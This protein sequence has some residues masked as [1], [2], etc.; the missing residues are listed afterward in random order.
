MP[1]RSEIPALF[2]S[3][4]AKNNILTTTETL[5]P[6]ECDGYTA[7]KSL[8]LAVLLPETTQQVIDIIKICQRETIPIVTRGAGTGLS[9]G[10]HPIS[11]G[12]LLNLSKLNQIL[13]INHQLQYAHV[14]PGVRNLAISEAASEFGLYYA[15]DPSSQI[16]CTIGGNI[17]E[18]SGGVHCLK[19]GLTVHNLLEVT[20]VTIDGELITIGSECYENPGYDMLALLAGSEGMLAVMV[21]AKVKLLPKPLH[22]EVILAAF[23]CVEEAG[24]AVANIIASGVIPAGLEMMDNAVINATENFCH[25]GYPTDA[26][27]ILLCELDGYDDSLQWEI[28]Q[29]TQQCKQSNAVTVQKAQNASEQ[30]LFWKGRKSAFPAIGQLS[31]DYLC[32]DGTIPRKH[33]AHVLGEI[34]NYSKQIG[35]AVANVFHAGDGNLHPLIMYDANNPGELEKAEEIGGKILELCVSV[36]GTITGEH[37]VGIEKLNQMCVQFKREELN[38]F[39]RIK[40]AFDPTHLLNPGKVIPTLQR[41]AEFGAM[42]VHRG[43]MPFKDLPRF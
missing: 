20:F 5:R 27:A 6:Y 22:K 35:L 13:E 2:S 25:A 36:G 31:P 30:E 37:G 9:G 3:C 28:E 15:P 24:S 43:E 39:E 18:N 10:A 26:A 40:E 4:L 7:Y 42:H 29:V 38:Q 32:M 14:G 1:N 17:A 16:A 33:L 23:N 34:S 11:N 21:E 8:P 12:I 19:Y 41:C